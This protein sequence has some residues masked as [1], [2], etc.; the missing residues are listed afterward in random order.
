[1]SLCILVNKNNTNCVFDDSGL[2]LASINLAFSEFLNSGVTKLRRA[3][4]RRLNLGQFAKYC[5]SVNLL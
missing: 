2:I 4:N 3:Q 1:L 5:F